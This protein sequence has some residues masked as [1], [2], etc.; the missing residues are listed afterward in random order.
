MSQQTSSSNADYSDGELESSLHKKIC[1]WVQGKL[2]CEL[3]LVNNNMPN[4]MVLT[5]TFSP[6]LENFFAK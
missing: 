3:G 4:N 6:K 1:G 5:H 2:V